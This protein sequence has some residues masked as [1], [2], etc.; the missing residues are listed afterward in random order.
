MFILFEGKNGNVIAQ[1]S[2]KTESTFR[3]RSLDVEMRL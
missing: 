3:L 1:T 2:L